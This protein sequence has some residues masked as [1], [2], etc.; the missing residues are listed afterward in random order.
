MA[1]SSRVVTSRRGMPWARRLFK[2]G[3]RYGKTAS[4]AT[5]GVAMPPPMRLGWRLSFE[6]ATMT[7]LKIGIAAAI[8]VFGVAVASGPALA[9]DAPTPIT[10]QLTDYR[11]APSEIDLVHGQSYVL[12][13]VNPHGG[14]HD[15]SAKAFFQS[16]TLTPESAAVVHDGDVEVK[17][18][19][20]ADIAFTAGAP[21]T[22]EMKCTHPMHAMFGMTGKIVVQ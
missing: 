13:L 3:R 9:Q 12:H 2:S 1:P 11:F 19:Q 7:G 20:S 14:G 6:R 10:V 4:N 22:Y 16:V 18:G 17:G 21:G 8:A 5:A 15:L